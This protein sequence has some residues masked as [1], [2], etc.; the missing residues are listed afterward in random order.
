[1]PVGPCLPD[2][3][4]GRIGDI[5]LGAA[6]NQRTVHVKKEDAPVHRHFLSVVKWG[7]LPLYYS[8]FP[9]P[10]QEKTGEKSF[11]PG[12][13]TL[14]LHINVEKRQKLRYNKMERK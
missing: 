4:Y 7:M 1:M 5:F 8:R 6:D 11:P 9:Q 10:V 2:R 12:V 14:S 13:F 3:L